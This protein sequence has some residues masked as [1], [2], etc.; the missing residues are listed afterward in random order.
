MR[1]ELVADGAKHLFN[2][3]ETD[4]AD[5]MNLHRISSRETRRQSNQTP[6]AVFCV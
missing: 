1:P 4:A 3:V 5:E 6:Q 2:G